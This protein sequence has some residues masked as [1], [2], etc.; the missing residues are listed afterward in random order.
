MEQY[1]INMDRRVLR[2]LGSQLYGDTPS[3]IGEL[4][5][6]SYDAYAKH[7]WIT[8]NQI[9]SKIIIEDDGI[10]M[11][12]TEINTSFLNIGYN[13][14]ETE[15]EFKDEKIKRKMMGRKG[16]GKL[17]AFS[18]SNIMYLYS[19]KNGNKYGCILDFIKLTNSGDDPIS[20]SANDISF[21]ND[22]LSSENSGTRIELWNVK[23]RLGTS[24]RFILS[25]LIRLFDVNDSDFSIL[26]R[27]NNEE[28][29]LLQ[30]GKL[31]YFS[32][33][34]S[35]L[36]MGDVNKDKLQ[37]VKLNSIETKYK[38]TKTFDDFIL[39]QG[40]TKNALKPLPYSIQVDKADGSSTMVDLDISGW[41]GTVKALPDLKLLRKNMD[42]EDTE[43]I[44]INDNRISLYSRGKLGEYDILSK[45]KTNTNN[46][47][48]VIGEFSVEVFE[49]NLL[50]DMAI[51]NR[52]GYDESDP[53]YTEVIKITKKLLGYIVKQKNII[54]KLRQED[55]DDGELNKIRNEF[56]EDNAIKLILDKRLNEEEKQI[57]QDSNTQF[58]RA[59][60]YNNSTKKVFISHNGEHKLYGQVIVDVLELYGMDVKSSVIFTQDP[61]LGVPQGKDIYDYLKECFRYDMLVIFLFS[62]AFYDSNIC[63]SEAGASWATN[64]NCLNVIIDINFGD[65]TKPSNSALSSM[66]MINLGDPLQKVALINFFEII[67]KKITNINVDLVRLQNCIDTILH[68]SDY[69]S[70]KIDKPKLFCPKRKFL[71]I[72]KC[73]KCENDMTLHNGGKVLYY[74]CINVKCKNIISVIC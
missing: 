39:E 47:A 49:D 24:Y 32:I 22:K 72:L 59:I 37:K 53:R 43:K 27:C 13:K 29:K 28:F 4:V 11:N 7:V 14:R 57:F 3:V 68:K 9:D 6:N 51:S 34:D 8:I 21:E 69:T 41:I 50:V 44:E 18:L 62:K 26:I 10:G 20:I 63:I 36:I 38:I 74:E 55:I 71:P 19:C 64:K 23:K 1:K 33:M 15:L 60:N 73:P 67:I 30:R 58:A 25:K 42:E 56:K 65:V 16:I 46:E 31:D 35:I 5:A 61:R 17:A 2:L 40:K 70:D 12:A 48:Y 52:R 45:I 54:S 66:K